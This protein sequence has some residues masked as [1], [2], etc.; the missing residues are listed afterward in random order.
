[1]ETVEEILQ[2]MEGPLRFASREGYRH[3]PLLRDLEPLMAGHVAAL[4]QKDWEALSP[5]GGPPPGGLLESFGEAFRGYDALPEEQKRERIALA[6]QLYEEIRRWLPRRVAVVPDLSPT[7]PGLEDVRVSLYQLA[8]PARYVRGVGPRIS[9]LLEKKGL[10]TVEDLLYFLPRR[11]EDRREIRKIAAAIFGRRETVVGKVVAAG[12]RQFGRRRVFEAA[13][14]D[15]TGTLLCKWFQGRSAYLKR[16]F[17]EGSTVILTGE[18]RGFLGGKE[19]IHPDYEVLDDEEGNSL[20][21]RRIVPVYSETEGLYQ[22]VLRRILAEVLEEYAVHLVSPIPPFLLQSRR[23]PAMVEAVRE[24]H[25][26][27]ADADPEELNRFS[28]PAHRRLIY[29]ELF[30]LQL[31]MALRRQGQTLEQ[32]I[33]FRTGGLLVKRFL[34]SLPFRLTG[35]QKRVLGEIAGDM[36]RPHRMNRLLQGDVGSGKTVVAFAAIVAACENGYQAA[37]M[38]P[39]EI[40][41]QQHFRNVRRWAQELGLRA[42]FLSGALKG[43]ERK[44]ALAA[45]ARGETQI[46]VGTHAL[47]QEGA[48]YRRLGLVV[49][50]EQHRFGVLQRATLR[51]K[52]GNPDV[53]VMTA[54]PI[55]RTLAMTVYGDLDVSILD[56]LPPGKQPVDTLVVYEHHRNRVYD[57]IRRE[58]QRGNQAFIVYPLVEESEAL[59]LKDATR[60]AEHLQKDV[61]PGF[62]VGLVT[63]RMKGSEKDA[64]MADF[65]AGKI[66]I[67]VSTTVI[68]VGIDIPEAS[69]MVI[70]HAE[71]FGLSQLHQLRGRVGR[72]GAASKCILLA[73][74]AGST[75]ARRRLQVMEETQD[76]FRIAEEDLALRGPGEFLGTR[77]SGLP[78]FRVANIVRDGRILAEARA[79]AFVLSE[80]DPGLAKPE[81]ALLKEVLLKRW[82]GRLELARVG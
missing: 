23:L 59:D 26:P 55:P 41:A 72:G 76:G 82:H 48:E 6:L 53:L 4:M 61:F 28:S 67:L 44:E 36:G 17:Q 2:R 46:I 32:G 69:V 43:S 5:P 24:V 22:K 15:G 12:F 1:M 25:F 58:I 45:I 49:I 52:G 42:G 14:E 65:A 3:L 19:M 21:F 73:G 8:T 71:R 29:D 13:V 64:V 38:A 34:T 60:M 47:I 39:T 27:G 16:V 68:E 56:E 40:L 74:H 54:T 10:V 70:E 63:G 57:T 35:A 31:G 30:F 62:A 80:R 66:H 77:Q 20:H 9:A 79:D 51:E 7:L 50:D 81:H 75:D 78:D 33:A 11:Y 18:V 37:F